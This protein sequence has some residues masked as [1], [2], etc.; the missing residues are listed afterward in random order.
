MLST[1]RDRAAAERALSKPPIL[2]CLLAAL[3]CQMLCAQDGAALYGRYC[4]SCHEPGSADRAPARQYLAEMS[5]ERIVVAMESGV[6][7]NQARPLSSIQR[8]AVAEYI[9]GKKLGLAK[10]E[11]EPSPASFCAGAP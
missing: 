11:D 7:F 5:P 8:D 1:C 3:L 9:S 6:M 2:P 10:A 4:G